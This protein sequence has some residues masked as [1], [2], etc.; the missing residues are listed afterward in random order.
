[1][2][3]RIDRASWKARGRILLVAAACLVVLVGGCR[4][5]PSRVQDNPTVSSPV[6]KVVEPVPEPAPPPPP[7][8]E[9]APEPEPEPEPIAIAILSSGDQ[10]EYESVR[11]ALTSLADEAHVSSWS[12]LGTPGRVESTL[13]EI[14]ESGA[15]NVIAI[16]M[17][18]ARAAR[19]LDDA[20]VVFCQ[21]FNYRQQGLLSGARQGVETIPDLG[22]AIELWKQM[23][24][25]LKTIGV[26]TGA[27]HEARIAAAKAAFAG[28]EVDLLHLVTTSDKETHLEFQRMLPEIDGYW[29]FPDNHV[30]SSATIREVMA[31][32]RRS[33]IGVLANDPRFHQVGAFISAADVPDEIARVAYSILN[34]ARDTDQFPDSSMSPLRESTITIRADIASELGYAIDGIPAELMVR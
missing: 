10:A 27:G 25:D 6:E 29:M 13:A 24:P 22:A 18:A 14:R 2:V 17:L 19:Q 7:A 33:R 21:V 26:I 12:L 4:R 16:G 1:M 28:H 23:D 8:P 9:L 32:A 30:L 5:R 3:E 15:S 11:L 31:L 20:K 34:E